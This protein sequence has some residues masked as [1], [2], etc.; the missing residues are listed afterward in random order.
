MNKSI[1]KYLLDANVFIEA[2]R[3]YYAFDI[4]PG[5]WE[6][7]LHH[8]N[9][10]SIF[11]IDYV[12]NEMETGDKLG[13]WIK[14]SAPKSFFC[15]TNE[16]EVSQQFSAIM[17]WV[18]SSTQ[19]KDEAKSGFANNADGWLTAYAKVHNYTVVTHEVFDPFTRKKIPIPNICKE[20]KVDC[21]DTFSML[22]NLKTQFN[23]E[24]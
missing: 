19:F 10:S 24:L 2:H 14:A 13:V 23:M 12:K 20:F 1:P 21:M 8:N 11:S 6:C 4:C 22:R 16:I 3:R 17:Q 7:L 9:E 5:F 18:Q 15:S